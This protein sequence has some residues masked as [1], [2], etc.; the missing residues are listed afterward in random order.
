MIG[1]PLRS[2]SVTRTG[3]LRQLGPL[4]SPP[5]PCSQDRA[6]RA[7]RDRPGQGCAPDAWRVARRS[8]AER[9]TTRRNGSPAGSRGGIAG[10]KPAA[11]S[12]SSPPLRGAPPV[13]IPTRI[14]TRLGAVLRA[15]STLLGG[16]WGIGTSSSAKTTFKAALGALVGEEAVVRGIT[17]SISVAKYRPHRPHHR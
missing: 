2:W 17:S 10:M 15:R 9:R 16:L 8:S 3:R 5:A 13:F 11:Q 4:R 6:W 7:M 14:E 1:L 12:C